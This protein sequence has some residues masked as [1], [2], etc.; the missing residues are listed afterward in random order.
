[1]FSKKN[2]SHL[3]P[4]LIR[5]GSRSAAHLLFERYAIW[6]RRWAHGRLP[7]WARGGVDTSDLMQ[8]AMHRTFEQL[9]RIRSVHVTAL[10]SY[11]QRTIQNRFGDQLRHATLRRYLALLN[12][13]I[14]LSDD[15]EFAASVLSAPRSI[16]PATARGLADALRGLVPQEM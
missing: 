7:Q 8:D 5:Q 6:L 15:I 9:P 11:L 14:R 2:G 3:N 13:S 10:R 1:M 16:R 12:E 4:R